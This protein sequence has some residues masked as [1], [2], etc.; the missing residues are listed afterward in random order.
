MGIMDRF[1][2]SKKTEEVLAEKT[3]P[4]KKAVAKKEE[5]KAEIAPAKAETGTAP[6][7]TKMTNRILIRPVVTEKAA[8][9]QSGNKYTFVVAHWAKKATIKS[10]VKE[11][12]GVEPVAVNVVNVQGHRVR[13]GQS[14]GKHS[15]F[16]KAIVT[17]P[18]GKTITIHEGV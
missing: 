11:V 16:K 9:A 13:F 5:V 6:I 4:A 2:K 18:P 17:L 8:S 15:D 7:V 12:Y 10:A 3:K 14:M 1:K